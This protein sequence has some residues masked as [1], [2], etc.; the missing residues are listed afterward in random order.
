MQ[1]F[2]ESFTVNKRVALTI[3]RGT[4][5]QSTN[6]WLRLRHDDIE[7][8]GEASP[9]AVGQRQTSQ[10]AIAALTRLMPSLADL[11]PFDTQEIQQRSRGIPSAAR[12]A[13]DM[14]LYD[15]QGKALKVPLWKLWGGDRDRIVPTSFTIGISTP[16]K[17][18]AR[19]R[20]WK[21]QVS[22]S[23]LRAV[24][25][26]LG[27]PE[28]I[29][30]DQ[31]M[32]EA[33]QDVVPDGAS[34]SVDANGGWTCSDALAMAH[35]LADRGVVHLEQPLAHGQ[36]DE[37]PQLYE[38]S[39]LPIM[40]DE[41]CFTSRAVPLLANRVHG[42]NIKLM[43]SGGLSEALRMVHTAQAHGL[44]IML[45]CYSDSALSN[46]AAAQLAP[47]ADYLDLDSHLN[48][49]DDPFTGAALNAGRPWPND[50]PGLG[51]RRT[52]AEA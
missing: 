25:I 24:K 39:P 50:A 38:R 33:V 6:V 34:I 43:K 9:F 21:E 46:T 42:I 30:A 41:S 27:S 47:F 7:G 5:A 3:S 35:W 52:N 11:S 37:L 17:A 26:K 48:L 45:G 15:W 22:S 32:F 1:L 40:A 31:A 18:Q 12:A 10:T 8:W 4:T 13:L 44:K 28:G 29:T 20:L 16:E 49:I 14:A 23:N 51:V 36:E 19:L 2:L